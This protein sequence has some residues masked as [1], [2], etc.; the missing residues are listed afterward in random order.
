MLAQ[1]IGRLTDLTLTGQKDQNIAALGAAVPQLIHAI[2][3][4]VIEVVVFL[5]LKR[6][7][8]HFHRISA[9][10]NHDDRRWPLGAFKMLGKALGINRGRSHHHLQ[11]GALGQDLLDV[12][13]QE[14]N[15]QAALVRLVND[16]RVVSLEQRVGLRLGQQ[17]AV[18]HQ[19]DG[20][21]LLQRVLKTHLVA[22][23]LTQRRVQL[24]GNALGHG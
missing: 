7:I 22:H 14:V 13:Q 5:F 21:A 20:S 24:F 6:A 15:V 19:L 4:G 11:V 1:V 3:N 10:R 17:D 16:Q 2:G 18:R 8:A 9:T 23:H 12:A